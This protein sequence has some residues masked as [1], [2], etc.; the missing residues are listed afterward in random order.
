MSGD[1]EAHTEHLEEVLPRISL[2]KVA[3]KEISEDRSGLN[4]MSGGERD[5]TEDQKIRAELMANSV[6]IGEMNLDEVPEDYQSFVKEDLHQLEQKKK[7]TEK[8]FE[9]A[10]KR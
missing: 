8:T 7:E 5:E 10:P 2:F 3:A 1:L 9:E 6:F 4:D